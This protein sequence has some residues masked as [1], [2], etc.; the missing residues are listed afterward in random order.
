MPSVELSRP[1]RLAFGAILTL[2]LIGCAATDRNVARLDA[3]VQTIAVGDPTAIS[4]P[5]L[6]AVMVQAGFSGDEVLKYGPAVRNAIGQA[7]GAQINDNRLAKALLT[8]QDGKLYV[9]S[10]EAGTFLRDL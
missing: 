3:D 5:V 8:V 4:A 6:A 9:S 2:T 10:R 7:G 1:L